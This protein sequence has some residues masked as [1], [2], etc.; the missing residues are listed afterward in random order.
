MPEHVVALVCVLNY[1]FVPGCELGVQPLREARST[2]AAFLVR[3]DD[4]VPSPMTKLGGSSNVKTVP[5]SKWALTQ[6]VRL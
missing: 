2:S 1:L 4:S 5:A 3:L 6:T